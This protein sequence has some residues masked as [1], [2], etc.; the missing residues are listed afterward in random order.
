MEF[1]FLHIL[2]SRSIDGSI[3]TLK[4]AIDDSVVRPFLSNEAILNSL[5][6]H[7]GAIN[8]FRAFMVCLLQ[9][10]D[11]PYD[12]PVEEKFKRDSNR[13]FVISTIDLPLLSL[14]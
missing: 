3:E 9:S 8:L 6:T 2:V 10:I 14:K 11:K 5:L 1:F 7:L 12:E 13:K 4:V